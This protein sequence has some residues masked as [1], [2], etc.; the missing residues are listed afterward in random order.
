MGKIGEETM[1]TS[2]KN[3]K[4]DRQVVVKLLDPKKL[5]FKWEVGKATH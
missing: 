3:W 4:A 5:S 2:F 1:A